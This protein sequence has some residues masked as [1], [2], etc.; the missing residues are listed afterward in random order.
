M[1]PAFSI[2]LP[3]KDQAP[4]LRL[5]L[6]ALEV[7][8][9][10]SPRDYEVIVVND[11]SHDAVEDVVDAE[12]AVA[13]YRLD[14]L[15]S[16]SRGARGVPRNLGVSAARGELIVFLDADALPS[17]D[18]LRMHA[19]VHRHDKHLAL[20]DTYVIPATERLLDP[21]DG[22]PFPGTVLPAPAGPGFRLS[23]SD[24]RGG[25]DRALAS[26]ARKGIYPDVTIWGKQV[27]EMLVEGAC[28][29]AWVGVIPHNLSVLRRT[30][31]ELGGFDPFLV[32][33]EGW[34]LGIR[35]MRSQC[36]IGMAPGARSFHLYHQRS[37]A[38]MQTGIDVAERIMDARY[39]EE[40]LALIQLW[41]S[42]CRGNPYLPAELNLASWRVLRKVLAD[43]EERRLI[44][45]LQARYHQLNHPPDRV[46]GWLGGA[47]NAPY[48]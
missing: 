22:T 14:L 34:D 19:Q 23:L 10:V 3:I 13:P 18:F 17:R 5:T 41:F 24:V 45:A 25:A 4:R 36:T 35:A 43:P 47:L 7:Q 21:S 30:F 28:P 38:Q 48:G 9:G 2:I 31:V 12:R 33:S 29:F 42:A 39:P 6:A 26:A 27:D 1:T 20:G 37:F 11:D 46:D 44:K 40:D 15:R 8:D 16:Q 32:H